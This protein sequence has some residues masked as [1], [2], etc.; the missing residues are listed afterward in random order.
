V[1]IHPD[2][3]GECVRRGSLEV[4]VMMAFTFLNKKR[5]ACAEPIVSFPHELDQDNSKTAW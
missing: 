2:N 4:P 3:A 5:A 1:D